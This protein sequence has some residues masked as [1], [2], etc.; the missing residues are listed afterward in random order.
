MGQIR[1][2]QNLRHRNRGIHPQRQ[3]IR[4]NIAALVGLSLALL[5]IPAAIAQD[6]SAPTAAGFDKDTAWQYLLKQCDYGPR[7]PG[8]KAHDDCGKYLQ[9]ELAKYCDEVHLQHLTHLW[10][11]NNQTLQM[12]NIIGTQ[13]WKDAKVR[14]VL[15]AHWDSR[16]FASQ[17]TDP[18]KQKMPILGADDGASGVAVLIELAKALHDQKLP[19]G[20]EYLLDDG[21]DLGPNMD[22]MLLGVDYYA[23]NLPD[24]KPQYGILLDMIGNKGVRVPIESN[25]YVASEDFIRKFYAFAQKVG[26]EATFPNK[27][28]DDIEDD[29]LPLIAAGIPTIDLIDFNYPYW[30]TL[31]DT[32]DKCSADSLGNVGTMLYKW[33]LQT[34]PYEVPMSDRVPRTISIGN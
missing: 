22:Q 9:T 3:T 5:T 27:F 14:I 13:N 28:G 30:H 4:G 29:H 7:V 2:R 26:L 12:D 19:I 10:T 33:I 8:T 18:I 24:P 1:H 31:Q 25:S 32:P 20:V 15:L 6:T 34:P 21:E 23:K 11:Y 17:E 16:P